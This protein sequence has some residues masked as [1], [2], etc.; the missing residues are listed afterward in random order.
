MGDDLKAIVISGRLSE[1]AKG[2]AYA[3]EAFSAAL[4]FMRS[5]KAVTVIIEFSVET[6]TLDFYDAVKVLKVPV[7]FS[8]NSLQP[9]EFAQ[10]GIKAADVV[11]PERRT[12]L[13]G[14]ADYRPRPGI[15]G[16]ST[17]I[18]PIKSRVL[19]EA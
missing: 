18:R 11:Y 1:A 5:A 7:V 4:A 9:S 10:F 17:T 2:R 13:E 16:S 19:S 12:R 8:A 6:D 3:F 14:F 15:R